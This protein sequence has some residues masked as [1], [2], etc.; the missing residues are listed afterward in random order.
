VVAV[1]PKSMALTIILSVLF[2]PLGM[3]YATVP[4]AIIMFFI[5]LIAAIFTAGFGLLVTWPITV[6]WAAVATNRYNQ[7]LLSGR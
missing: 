6:I 3:L 1:A 2:G 4:G 5:N 7:Q